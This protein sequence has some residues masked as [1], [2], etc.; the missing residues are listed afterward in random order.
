MLTSN[1]RQD[2]YTNRLRTGRML[3]GIVFLWA[4]LCSQRLGI[5]PCGCCCDGITR[6]ETICRPMNGRGRLMVVGRVMRIRIL[7]IHCKGRNSDDDS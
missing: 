5:V 6:G 2:R 3:L 7:G 4:Q 1:F